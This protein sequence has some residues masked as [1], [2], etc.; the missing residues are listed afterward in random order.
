M[1][2]QR[3][4][5]RPVL[6]RVHCFSLDHVESLSE[7][8][9]ATNPQ[10]K[11]PLS[12]PAGGAGAL[13]AID[14]LLSRY[15][16]EF[17]GSPGP[18]YWGFVNGGVTPAALAGDWLASAIDQNSQLNGDGAAAFIEHEALVMLRELFDLPDEFHGVFVTGGTMANYVGLGIAL[19]RLGARRG[20]D[21]SGSGVAALGPVR[22]VTGASHSSIAKSAAMLGIGRD[23]IVEAPQ[24]EGREAVDPQAMEQLLREHSEAGASLI[25]VA[26]AGTVLTGDFDDIQA[27]AELAER[28]GAHLHVDGAF[29][30]FAA[31]SGE[32]RQLVAGLARADTVA[33]DGHKFLNV[34]YDSGFLFARALGEQVELFKNVSS[35]QLP[36][37]LDPKHYIHLSPQNSRR[38]RALPAWVSL[39]AYGADGQ[40][41]IVERCCALAAELGRRLEASDDFRLLAP[42]RYCVVCFQLL[43]A[44]RP[45]DE[46]ET[47]AFLDRVRDDGRVFVT[48]GNLRGTPCVR[49]AM[50]N[51]S[52]T[53]ADL[54][55]A[56]EAFG[57]CIATSSEMSDGAREVTN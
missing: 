27:L 49:L 6:E 31:C 3:D 35:Y 42:V 41:A 57:D 40:A 9:A 54:E 36:P 20:V 47:R 44:G 13:A 38:L 55:I 25:I 33:S 51:W 2:P 24:L 39:R 4:D 8:R 15:G 28:F 52:T 1:D 5:L 17:S 50:V 26:N 23:A 12:L 29:G 30:A 34:P 32:H 53:E 45:A 37:R 43:I 7:H 48:P 16:S 11:E 19:Q 22:I 56:L 21:V 18:R 10:A 46:A 14:E